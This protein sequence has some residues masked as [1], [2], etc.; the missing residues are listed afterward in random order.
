M[1]W[2]TTSLLH[3]YANSLEQDNSISS[4]LALKILQSYTEVIDINLREAEYNIAYL[5]DLLR[6]HV[7]TPKHPPT[8]ETHPLLTLFNSFGT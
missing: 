4:A 6:S 5:W 7:P 2:I 3:V 8:Q 1:Q